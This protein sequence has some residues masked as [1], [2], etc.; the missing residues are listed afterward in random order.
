MKTKRERFKYMN[1]KYKYVHD[2]IIKKMKLK[3]TLI[4]S[5]TMIEDPL[6][7]S[8]SGPKLKYFVDFIMKM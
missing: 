5:N 1:I 4:G 3:L 7:K 6:T 2:E 8:I